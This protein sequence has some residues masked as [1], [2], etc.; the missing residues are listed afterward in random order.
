MKYKTMKQYQ[1]GGF[2]G[3]SRPLSTKRMLHK[4]G[5]K[6]D[7]KIAQDELDEQK[8]N[9]LSKSGLLGL[10]DKV[11]RGVS[12]SVLPPVVG[13][14]VGSLA[15]DAL[16]RN[17]PKVAT[18]DSPT[19]YLQSDFETLSDY[20]KS[21]GTNAL[22]RA[23]GAGAS[24]LFRFAK[25]ELGGLKGIKDRVKLLN[26]GNNPMS[27]ATKDRFRIGADLALGVPT[28]E[29]GTSMALDAISQAKNA[30][31]PM[32]LAGQS[33]PFS[34]Q[35]FLS[36]QLIGLEDLPIN[37]PTESN[38]STGITQGNSS[39]DAGFGNFM[40]SL[41]EEYQ[42]GGGMMS[43]YYGGGMAKKKKKKKYGYMGGG[44]LDMMPYA[45]RIV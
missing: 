3:R 40:A 20:E 15:S 6:R 36:K 22:N 14:F 30:S 24:G 45:R 34:L 28:G 25:D 39:W 35:N 9:I 10:A 5:Q 23:L 37:I 8:A 17:V 27:Q 18:G 32:N 42:E 26:L 1:E 2:F 44:L 38:Q 19:G 13:D 11:I 21:Q 33:L 4:I 12:S 16:K 31:I 43:D 7:V 41:G 29:S